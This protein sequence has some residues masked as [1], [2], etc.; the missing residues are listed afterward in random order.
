MQEQIKRQP[1]TFAGIDVGKDGLDIFIHPIGV[2]LKAKNAKKAIQALIGELSQHGVDLVAME[3]TSTYHRLAHSMLHDAGIAVAV[4]NPFRS[5]QFANSLGRLAKT[6]TIDAQ[7]LSFF[8]ERMKPEPTVPPDIQSRQ[9]RDLNT[10]R[11]QVLDE[12]CDLKRQL[13]TTDHPM[14]VRQIKARIELGKRHKAVLEKEIQNVI[15]S[16]PDLKSKCEILISIPGIGNTTAAI[17]LADLAELGQVNAKEIA[18]LAG[19]APLNW[20]SG[21]KNGNRMIRGGRKHVRNALYM[22]AVACIRQSNSLG[23]TYRHL[24]G[25]GKNAKVALTAVMRKMIILA[26]TLIGENRMWQAQ[27]PCQHIQ[28]EPRLRCLGSPLV[29]A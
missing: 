16:N 26:N 10:A 18:A 13:H 4:I 7:T 25:R 11:R 22:C 5:R 9:L 21:T 20:D 28:A 14:A 12:I 19:V 27:S 17:L 1:N 23:L 3:A 15:A 8:A 2:R 6:D 24:I 29:S